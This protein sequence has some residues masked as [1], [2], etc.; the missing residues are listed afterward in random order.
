MAK[1][2]RNP[3]DHPAPGGPD[4]EFFLSANSQ[5]KKG[6]MVPMSI[7]GHKH[8]VVIGQRNTLPKEALQVLLDAKSSTRVV[9]TEKYDPH[10]G[11]M[12][13]KQEDFYNPQ[14]KVVY[15]QEYDVEII[16]EH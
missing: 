9:D 12:P 14:T 4:V 10:R 16:K 2:A 1:P 8:Y 11:G 5:Y 3:K 6:E 7:N 15:Q 13:R